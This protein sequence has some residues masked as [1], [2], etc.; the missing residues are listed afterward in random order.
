MTTHISEALWC[1]PIVEALC[2]HK[3][4]QH[5]DSGNTGIYHAQP[6]YHTSQAQHVKSHLSVTIENIKVTLIS[7]RR[8]RIQL[9]QTTAVTSEKVPQATTCW[10]KFFCKH[11]VKQLLT[12][13]VSRPVHVKFLLTAS[14]TKFLIIW[15]E[16]PQWLLNDFPDK[17][18]FFSSFFSYVNKL[19]CSTLK[20]Q[21]TAPLL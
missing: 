2:L 6:Q 15:D 16:F 12:N 7:F 9:S 4:S 13:H 3:W 11:C 10:S 18:I 14:M 17:S 8:S 1:V 5:C 20:A 21:I 19:Q